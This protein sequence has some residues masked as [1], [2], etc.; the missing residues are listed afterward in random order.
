MT[1]V[2]EPT[3]PPR[4]SPAARLDWLDPIKALALL[5][6]LLNHLVEE[7]GAGPW[8]TNP[9]ASWPALST[10]LATA[11][12]H[13]G[14]P[15]WN[16][17]RMLGWLGDAAPG[18]FI[19][20][21]GVGLTLSALRNGMDTRTFYRRRVFRL[22]PLYIAMHVVILAGAL[23]V[24]GNTL[25]F[26]SPATLLSVLGL[27]V[28]RGLFFYISPA[29]WFVW[30][31]LQLY[32]VYPLLFRGLQRFG[33]ARFFAAAL[34]F[35]VI[36]RGIGLMMPT[37][38]YDWLTGMFFGSRLAEFASGMVAAW[39][40]ARSSEP[41]VTR[42]LPW[43]IVL[44]VLGLGAQVFLPTVVVSN[45]LVTLGMTGIFFGIWRLAPMPWLTR[46]GI[47]SYAIFL[48]HQPPLKWTA[49]WFRGHGAE[50][51][52]A[53]VLVL[54]VSWPIAEWIERAVNA[55]E[56]DGARV[57]TAN[58]RLLAVASGVMVPLL[59]FFVE[60]QLTVDGRWQRALCWVLAIDLIA[61][62]WLLALRRGPRVA[63]R[64]AAVSAFLGLFLIPAESGFLAALVGV[65][66][67]LLVTAT[68]G[69]APGLVATGIVL[70]T[71]EVVA[72]RVAP[73][74]VGGWGERPALEI[75][76]TR[77]FGL[78]PNKTTHL[79]YNDYDYI[80]RT[81]S[82]GLASP[83]IPAQRAVPGTFRVLAMGDAFTMP[84]A[85]PYEQSYPA[86]LQT[87][88]SRCLAPRPVQVINAG[89]TGYGPLEELAQFK[90]LGPL[91]TPDVVVHEF[92]VNDWQDITI[93]ADQRR[94]GIGLTAGGS[95][96]GLLRDRSHLVANIRR[97][98][99]AGVAAVTGTP[100]PDQTWKLMLPYFARGQNSLYDTTNVGRMTRFMA[101]FRD[102]AAAVHS[103]LLVFYT[104]AGVSVLPRDE[105]A[106]L[107]RS[108]IPL[109]DPTDYDLL[110]PYTTLKTITDSLGVTMVDLTGPLKS[111]R[112]Q[113]TYYPNAWHWTADGQ[114]AAASAMLQALQSQGVI[115]RACSL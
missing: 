103:R 21:S 16:A 69:W 70:V 89:V 31:I 2:V 79:R 98:Y 60:P 87:A 64:I 28:T 50:H 12:P 35:T 105:I 23:F 90:E 53:A 85:L 76:P 58:A 114:Q 13:G 112:L 72:K 52:A 82:Y 78:I 94:R 83:E 45:L 51:F 75:N 59:L 38:R 54:A 71:G 57:L 95:I 44:Y 42:V 86:L 109:S 97:A 77:A 93:G 41:S 61:V 84:E 104:P 29:W 15:V 43:A 49:V 111:Y 27:R 56:R 92:F 26:G 34:A 7:F 36:S 10:R 55:V 24:P 40:L 80:V 1:T 88:L 4:T 62:A 32:L 6:I 102:A 65:L 37:I 100:S 107:P 47:A 48:L 20:A 101:A 68:K 30:L 66:I 5:G 46:L 14:S 3:A 74:E 73:R 81:N 115:D 96:R 22:Y 19:F 8:F 108:G 18:V 11:V 17:V 63:L 39:W 91:F 33:P 9:P 99:E 106:Y 25:S 67:G 113:P 110:R